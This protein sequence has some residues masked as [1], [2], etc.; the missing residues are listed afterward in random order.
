M[1]RIIRGVLLLISA[2]QF[3][4]A[5]AFFFQL[6]PAIALWPFPGSTPLTYIFVASILAAAAASTLWV[7]ATEQYA[8]VAGIGLDYMMILIPAGILAMQIFRGT[9]NQGMLIFEI[10]CVVGV[11]FGATLLLWSMRIPLDRT[12][13]LPGPVRWSFMLFI[14]A[15]L[16]VSVQL[17]LKVPNILPWAIT[18]ELSVMIGWMFFGAMIYFVYALVRPSWT[19]AAG[20]LAGFLAYDIVLLV[21]FLT[22]LPTVAPEHRLGLWVYTG[23]VAFSGILATYYLFIHP[24][25]RI[26][27][28]R[29][30]VAAVA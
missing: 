1:T 17:I 15:L 8:A 14:I 6:L 9:G 2:G 29:G 24:T 20:Q 16:G 22:R 27:S 26:W 25:T 30:Q 12:I 10:L 13:P 3:L 19:N 5:I 23:V 21:P 18:P 11:L 4:M 7:A 28:A